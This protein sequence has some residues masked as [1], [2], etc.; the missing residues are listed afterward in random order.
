MDRVGTLLARYAHLEAPEKVVREAVVRCCRECVDIELLSHEVQVRN[1]S[2]RLFT[3][4]TIRSELLLRK[5]ELMRCLIE[6]G[7]KIDGIQ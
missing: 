7:V 3:H 6:K 2:V 1:K 4:P 5:G